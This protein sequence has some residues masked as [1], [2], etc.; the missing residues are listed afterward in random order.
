[1]SARSI[2]LGAIALFVLV[3]TPHRPLF[4]QTRPDYLPQLTPGNY[5]RIRSDSVTFRGKLLRVTAER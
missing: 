5:T 4:A 1:M 3:C 2:V